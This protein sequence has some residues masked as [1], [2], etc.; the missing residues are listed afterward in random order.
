MFVESLNSETGIC[1]NAGLRSCCTDRL[2]S[3]GACH[4]NGT[5]AARPTGGAWD[6]TRFKRGRAS[7]GTARIELEKPQTLKDEN[8][9]AMLREV[10]ADIMV[11]AAYGLLLPQ[12]VLDMPRLGCLNIHGSLLPRW[13]GAAPVQ[14]AIGLAMQK[15]ALQ[16]CKWTPDWIPERYCWKEKSPSLRTRQALHCLKSWSH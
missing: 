5:D 4:R 13:R 14:R 11:V 12:A 8:V 2:A 6:E 3:G 1:R 9:Q 16:S 15:R 10:G 7:G